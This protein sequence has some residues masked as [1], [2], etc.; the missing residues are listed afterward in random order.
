MSIYLDQ[1]SPVRTGFLV[2]IMQIIFSWFG[3][4]ELDHSLSNYKINHWHLT[5]YVNQ[6]HL[7]KHTRADIVADEIYKSRLKGTFI[8]FARTKTLT[9]SK[10][11]RM[12]GIKKDDRDLQS[13]VFC[14]CLEGTQ[15]WRRRN[16]ILEPSVAPRVRAI[17]FLEQKPRRTGI[18]LS[19]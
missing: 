11:K 1:G 12:W 4:L 17:L 8:A 6:V 18:Y 9:W 2:F 7:I 19:M 10:N 16:N 13:A 5:V 15:K 14:K 3:A